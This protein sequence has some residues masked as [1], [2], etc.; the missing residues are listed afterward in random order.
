MKALE[1]TVDLPFAA[2]EQAV[3]DALKEGGGGG[4][5]PLARRFELLRQVP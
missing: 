5:G 1:T 4:V 3:R 2:A